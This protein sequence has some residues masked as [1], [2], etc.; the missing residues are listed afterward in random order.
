MLASLAATFNLSSSVVCD[1]FEGLPFDFNAPAYMGTWYED[2]HSAN[3]RF[4]P[5]SNVCVQA[6]YRDLDT[7]TGKFTVD[8]SYQAS[9]TDSRD[10]LIG[11]GWCP[12]KLPGGECFVT[13]RSAPYPNAPNYNVIDTDYDNYSIV[14]GCAE[15]DMAFLFFLSREPVLSDELY[16]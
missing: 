7:I 3:Q 5:D 2:S 14:Y 6:D 16:D 11:E 4:A 12:S 15:D 9:L 13:F 10:R 1:T 8:N